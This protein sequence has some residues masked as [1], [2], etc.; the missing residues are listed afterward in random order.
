VI[1]L[2][3]GGFKVEVRVGPAWIIERHR[4]ASYLEVIVFQGQFPL[5]DGEAAKDDGILEC[6]SLDDG[7]RQ[8]KRGRFGH[9]QLLLAGG[10]LVIQA[11]DGRVAMVPAQPDKFVEL[12][13]IPALEG[14]TWNYPALAGDELFIRNDREA[15]CYEL[16][17]DGPGTH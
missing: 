1:E 14:R 13:S 12:G 17:L 7:R 2:L 6:V 4:S 9:G 15:A 8:W 5:I 10:L 3:C 11:E 16:P